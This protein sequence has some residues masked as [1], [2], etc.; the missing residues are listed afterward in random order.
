MTTKQ[1]LQFVIFVFLFIVGMAVLLRVI[2]YFIP[3]IRITSWYRTPEKNREVGGARRSAHLLGWAADIIP[4]R[5]D[6]ENML[7]RFFPFVLNEADHI[8]IGWY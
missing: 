5:E 7:R 3:G 1:M 2:L 4:V 6:V 8:H